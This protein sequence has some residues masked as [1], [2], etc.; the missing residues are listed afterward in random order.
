MTHMQKWQKGLLAGAVAGVI[1]VIPMI[2]QN[3]TWDANLS[4]F[5]FWVTTG[6][7]IAVADLPLKG[8]VKGIVIAYGLLFP[9]AFIIGWSNPA[10]LIPIAIMTLILG[11]GVGTA[12]ERI[13]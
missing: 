7:A 10:N 1:D 3:L 13:Q 5:F 11:A 9:L 6:T 2:L 4:A 8:A 12:I